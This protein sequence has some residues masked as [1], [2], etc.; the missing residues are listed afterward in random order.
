MTGSSTR[1]ELEGVAISPDH[2]VDGARLASAATFEVRS[3]LDWTRVLGHVARGDAAIANAA[4]TSASTAFPR[5]A[6]LS[7]T[8][9]GCLF[10]SS[11]AADDPIRFNLGVSRNC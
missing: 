1:F 4:L 8:A 2:Y 5:W 9:R 10:Y 3:P 6:A 7:G 11:V